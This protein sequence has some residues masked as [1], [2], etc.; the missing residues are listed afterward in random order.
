MEI[1]NASRVLDGDI[2]DLIEAYLLSASADKPW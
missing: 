2:D 1:G